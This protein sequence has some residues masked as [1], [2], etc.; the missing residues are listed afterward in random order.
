MAIL[1]RLRVHLLILG[2]QLTQA[3]EVVGILHVV[4]DERV[5]QIRLSLITLLRIL[6]AF[7]CHQVLQENAENVKLK[8]VDLHLNRRNAQFAQTHAQIDLVDENH[9]ARLSLLYKLVVLVQQHVQRKACQVDSALRQVGNADVLHLQPE[10]R[11]ILPHLNLDADLPHV[12]LHI[13]YYLLNYLLKASNL[14]LLLLINVTFV[15]EVARVELQVEVKP[16]NAYTDA[17][18]QNVL[19][20]NLF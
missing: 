9:R 5:H 7:E 10:K 11:R 18:V 15:R 17:F 4:H 1:G 14:H 3:G 19:P 12:Q 16:L 2:F 6:E 8:R 20:G 13:A